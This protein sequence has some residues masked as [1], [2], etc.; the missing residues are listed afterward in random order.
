MADESK[1]IEVSIVASIKG[2]LSGLQGA[3]QA[4]TQSAQ[5][6]QSSLNSIQGGIGAVGKAFVG[7]SAILAG[8]SMFKGAVDATLKWNLEAMKLARTLGITTQ[9]ASIL[10]LAL[11]DIFTDSE[12]YTRAVQMMTRQL[13]SGGEGF[14]KLGVDVRDSSGH[15]KP[16]TQLMTE[17]LTKLNGLEQGTNRNAA[18]MAIFGRSWG[19]AQ[20]LLKLNAQAMEEARQKAERLNLVVGPEAVEMTNQYRAAMNDV[21]D[22]MNSL[23]VQIGSAIMP[24]LVKLGAWFG[25]IGP[26]LAMVLAGT[27]KGLVT[28]FYLLKFAIESVVVWVMDFFLKTVEGFKAVGSVMAKLIKG[29][30]K[31]AIAE[32]KAGSDRIDAITAESVKIQ[33]D[34]YAGLKKDISETW[35]PPKVKPAKTQAAA[36]GQFNPDAPKDDSKERERLAREA[37]MR[38][39]EAIVEGLKLQ[40]DELRNNAAERIKL[41]EQ[42]IAEEARIHGKGSKEVIAAERDLARIKREIKAEEMALDI[43]AANHTRDWALAKIS[44]EEDALAQRRALGTL[45]AEQELQELIALEDRKLSVR[46]AALAVAMQDENLTEQ[47]RRELRNQNELMEMEHQ[48]RLRQIRMQAELEQQQ[49]ITSFLQ[50]LT[51]AFQQSL[52]GILGATMSWSGAMKNIWKGLGSMIDQMIAK[53]ATD[54]IAAELRK[55]AISTMVKIKEMIL[56]KTAAASAVATTATTATAQITAAGAVAGANAA[57][58]AA[59][60]PVIGWSIAIPAM[61]AVMGAVL[62]LRGSISS[63]AGGWDMVPQDQVAQLHKNEMVLPANLAQRVRDM[64]EPGGGAPAGDSYSVQIHALDSRSFEDTLR[65]NQGGLVKII[66]EAARNGRM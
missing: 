66:K 1:Q 56:N 34:L 26:G 27:L 54:W 49:S 44:M 53:M 45:S 13:N 20:K 11:G 63:A 42:V 5:G 30:F 16:S 18:G 50:P 61:L 3:G 55:L 41:Q 47:Q 14:K 48:A 24:V 7:I 12:T 29:D 10:N 17:V 25:E 21:D 38:E 15:L 62:A 40:M 6:M 22:V 43:Q 59:Q 2:L 9:E 39:H 23:K 31:G 28:A 57:A 19:E 4:V 58:S 33:K 46:R 36:D 52:Q 32:A 65:R 64:T 37:M 35:N 60:T 51:N 8:G